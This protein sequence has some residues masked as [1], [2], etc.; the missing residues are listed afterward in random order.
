M[1]SKVKSG[2]IIQD[3]LELL[4]G[5]HSIP[6]SHWDTMNKIGRAIS[7]QRRSPAKQGIVIPAGSNKQL[8]N[9]YVCARESGCS[10]PVEIAV[11][12]SEERPDT[13]HSELLKVIFTV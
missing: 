13:D 2:C 5:S 8:A 9:A 4:H 1:L 12:G 10:L 3:R 11:Y 6:A 7:L